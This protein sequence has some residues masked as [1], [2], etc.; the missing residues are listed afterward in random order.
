MKMFLASLVLLAVGCAADTSP[1]ADNQSAYMFAIEPCMVSSQFD[2]PF[3][4]N[5]VNIGPLSDGTTVKVRAAWSPGEPNVPNYFHTLTAQVLSPPNYAETAN[6]WDRFPSGIPETFVNDAYT[7]PGTSGYYEGSEYP[8][9]N[10]SQ[11][12]YVDFY[13][14]G[15]T[16]NNAPYNHVAWVTVVADVKAVGGSWVRHSW[17]LY[18]TDVYHW[19]QNY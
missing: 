1:T 5:W 12:R 9:G 3:H 10:V 7:V 16:I 4:A 19:V 15:G 18:A 14:Y 11:V 17:T 8:L 6:C 13:G 2:N